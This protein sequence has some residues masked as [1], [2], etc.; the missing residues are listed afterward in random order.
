MQNVF[1]LQ[2]YIRLEPDNMMIL[3]V[4]FVFAS[5]FLCLPG[6][7]KNVIAISPLQDVLA[8]SDASYNITG[9]WGN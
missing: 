9:V 2:K 6:K 3:I 7:I 4:V 5:P 8:F 1:R